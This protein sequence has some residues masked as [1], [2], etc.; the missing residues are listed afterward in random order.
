MT[1]TAVRTLRKQSKSNAMRSCTSRF[2]SLVTTPDASR[3]K[4]PLAHHGA[5][6]TPVGKWQGQLLLPAARFRVKLAEKTAP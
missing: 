5:G 2:G 1:F 4:P 3:I 6:F